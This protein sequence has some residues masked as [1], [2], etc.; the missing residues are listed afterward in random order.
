MRSHGTG[1][2]IC[3][4]PSVKGFRSGGFFTD[5]FL[6]AAPGDSPTRYW[7]PSTTSQT[8]SGVHFV[9][10]GAWFPT[11][12]TLEGLFRPIILSASQWKADGFDAK[13]PGN[14]QNYIDNIFSIAANEG[15]III[16]CWTFWHNSGRLGGI[17]HWHFGIV[18]LSVHR[19]LFKTLD[20]KSCPIE[21][22]NIYVHQP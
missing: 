13:L 15:A 20:G 10:S 19:G 21:W 9:R 16:G 18:S 5:P 8:S 4:W 12:I 22:N 14:I 17:L 7:N 1:S 11:N 3:Q 6:G 2:S